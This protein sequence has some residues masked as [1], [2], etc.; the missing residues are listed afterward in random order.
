MI[1]SLFV[2]QRKMNRMRNT[3]RTSTSNVHNDENVLQK[4]MR[5][6]SSYGTR[7]GTTSQNNCLVRNENQS[8]STPRPSIATSSFVF[9]QSEMERHLQIQALLYILA[10][11]LSYVF[12]YVRR[13]VYQKTGSSP[14]V[15]VLIPR[16]LRPLQGL[17]N[18]IIYTRVQVS[19]LK[20]RSG[21]SWL[22]AFF[23]VVTSFD[24][25]DSLEVV[26]TSRSG[27]R[28]SV[29][30]R[31]ILNRRDKHNQQN[32]EEMAAKTNE[33]GMNNGVD[34]RDDCD[35]NPHS[36]P[37]SDGEEREEDLFDLEISIRE[38][39]NSLHEMDSA[40]VCSE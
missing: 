11:L 17:F 9:R 20:S 10:F 3:W 2:L 18:I 27:Q 24:D 19:R 16:I 29:L 13:I 23:K 32:A 34:V 8:S 37:P 6:M 14:F 31:V 28:G 35:D 30:S 25:H 21:Y 7:S 4:F 33:D 22:K 36:H 5:R 1:R 26:N 40:M 39:S 15:L 12:I 38:S